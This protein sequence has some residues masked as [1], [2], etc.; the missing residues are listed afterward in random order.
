MDLLIEYDGYIAAKDN[1]DFL[2]VIKEDI[3]RTSVGNLLETKKI[4]AVLQKYDVLNHN[5]RI[6][7]KDVLFNA[8]EKY[9]QKINNRNS[10]GEV[11]HPE[12]ASIDLLNIGGLITK[13]WWENNT[14][15]G[16]IE[17]PITRGYIQMGIISHPADSIAHSLLNNYKIGI[18]SRGIGTVKE[19]G[20]S[21]IVQSDF[22]FI[23]WDFVDNPSTPNAWTDLNKD[24]LKKYVDENVKSG[25]VDD[26]FTNFLKKWNK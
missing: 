24:N 14:L 5:G 20:G 10:I 22:E 1:V 18:S 7:P 25:K 2:R 21:K 12:S 6:Y 13:L 26:K 17:L 3:E 11:N 9:Q 19:Q 16:E 8:V 4:Y 15:M 23:C